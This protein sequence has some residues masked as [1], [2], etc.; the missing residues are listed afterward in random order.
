MFQAFNNRNFPLKPPTQ[1]ANS[2]T[3]L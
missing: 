3:W 2:Q 1:N